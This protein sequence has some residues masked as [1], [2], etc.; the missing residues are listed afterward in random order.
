[1]I[2]ELLEK[3][4][5]LIAACSCDTGCPS[6]IHSPKCGSGN[7]PLDK[8]AALLLAQALLGKVP[9]EVER[10]DEV[11]LPPAV[12]DT[13]RVESSRSD[14]A[15][16]FFDIETQRLADEVGGWGN[17]HLMRLAVAV[18]YDRFTNSFE[19]FT[20]DKVEGLIE[21]LQDFDLVVGFNIKRF[22]YLVLGAY[23]PLDF[24]AVPTF[25]ILV[26]IHQRLG[27]RLSLSHLAEQTLG[28][29]KTADGIQAV[30]WFREGN[31]DE[32][33]NYCRDDVAITREL[34]EFGLSHGYLIYQTRSFKR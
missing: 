30:R 12:D 13:D 19:I 26:D 6:C 3:T 24:K 10:R 23:T 32:L 21:R 5:A 20:E 31:L 29:S 27:F 33:T 1:M 25:D 15:I 16:G 14:P 9:L 22:D 11:K 17:I 4:A 34:F 8:A 18:L 7:K 2:E 28:K